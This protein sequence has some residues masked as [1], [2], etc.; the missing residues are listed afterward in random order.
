MPGKNLPDF[1]IA[2]APKAGTSA[3]INYLN[4]SPECSCITTLQNGSEPHFFSRNY[5][6]GVSWYN[7][8]FENLEANQCY[9]EKSVSYMVY[10]H[11]ARRIFDLIPRVKLIFVLRNPVDRAFS[12]YKANYQRGTEFLSF[13]KAIK[14]EKFR[15][16]FFKNNYSY[17]QR[18]QYMD[19]LKPYFDFFDYEQLYFIIYEE[20]KSNPSMVLSD[21]SDFIGIDRHFIKS[22]DFHER[23]NVSLLPENNFIQ[24]PITFYK[25]FI[26]PRII[27]SPIDKWLLRI[28]K[29]NLSEQ[30]FTKIEPTFRMRLLRHFKPYNEFLA[31]AIG[32][33]LTFWND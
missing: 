21:L 10:P 18:G 8:L 25:K 20:F 6:K 26:R 19:F 32:K 29:E 24:L 15:R 22:S 12:Q 27:D 23:K 4:R 5:Q 33:D 17:I 16:F 7:K 13:K 1:I 30:G 31:Q 9:G 28:E 2:G 3:L 14:Q 11:A